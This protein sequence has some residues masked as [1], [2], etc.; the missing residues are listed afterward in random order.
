MVVMVDVVVTSSCAAMPN[1][2]RCSICVIPST[3]S[4]VT[5]CQ[6]AKIS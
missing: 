3:F 1:Y 6:E 2:G 4:L 5:A